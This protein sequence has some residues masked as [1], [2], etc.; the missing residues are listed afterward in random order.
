MEV[1]SMERKE[2]RGLTMVY[3]G[4][5]KGKTTAAL[6][7][8]LRAIGHG[9]R[10]YMV[11]FMKGDATG[12]LDAVRHYLSERMTI[13][14]SGSPDFITPGALADRDLALARQ[15][16]ELARTAAMSGDYDLVI[17]DEANV[18]MDFGLLPRADVAKL[19]KERPAWVD[20]VLT[21]R[22]APREITDLAD[23]VSEV[24]EIKHHYQQGIEAREGIEF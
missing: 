17:L 20:L 21:G 3:T 5:G 14:Q 11:Q 15:G 7:L 8:A 16:L 6:G 10:V 12:E 13:V 9:F 22:S 24:R 4:D 1:A 18:A 23:L 19:I 2:R